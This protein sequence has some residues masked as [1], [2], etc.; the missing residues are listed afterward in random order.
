MLLRLAVVLVAILSLHGAAGFRLSGNNRLGGRKLARMT[1]VS[2]GPSLGLLKG[3][4][5]SP[6]VFGRQSRL[7]MSTPGGGADPQ[8]PMVS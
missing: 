8:N 6:G 5:A 4:R 7:H 2:S 1:R 3:M